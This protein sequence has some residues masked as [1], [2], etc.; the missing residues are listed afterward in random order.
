VTISTTPSSLTFPGQR[1]GI[2]APHRVLGENTRQRTKAGMI[3]AWRLTPMPPTG[4]T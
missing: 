4:A 3:G 1:C 2:P